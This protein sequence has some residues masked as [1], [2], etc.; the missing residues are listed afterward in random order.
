MRLV[1]EDKLIAWSPLPD[2]WVKL[3]TDVTSK[4]KPSFAGV[5]GFIRDCTS[6][7]LVAFP[8]NVGICTSVVPEL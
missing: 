1:K 2:M 6:K 7:F 4:G 8:L 5:G 3:N